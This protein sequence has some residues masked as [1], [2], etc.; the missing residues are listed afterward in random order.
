MQT[1]ISVRLVHKHVYSV[2]RPL[3]VRNMEKH[4]QFSEKG[5]SPFNH[6]RLNVQ[7][8]GM[9]AILSRRFSVKLRLLLDD[10]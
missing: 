10:N 7:V 9:L 4:I 8:H 3:R 5:E 1:V 6:N 2:S